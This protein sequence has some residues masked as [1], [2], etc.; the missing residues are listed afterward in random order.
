MF[1]TI[2][3][4]VYNRAKLIPVLF[5]SLQ[6][7]SCHD[8]E[9][10]V[11]DDGSKDDI[12]KVMS[13]LMN[14][15]HAF[16]IKFFSRRNGGKHRA[17]NQ[18]VKKAEGKYFFIVDSDDKLTLDAVECIK[19][20]C[21]EID[22]LP[23]SFKFAGVSGLRET[24]EGKILGESG[25]GFFKVDAS[26]LE[27]KKYRLRGDKAEIYKTEV[28]KKYPFKEIPHENFMTEE[29]VWNKIAADGYIL[30]WYMKPI[31]IGDYLAGG[32]TKSAEKRDQNNYLGLAYATSEA[33]KLKKL[34]QKMGDLHYFTKI[35]LTKD[36]SF[37]KISELVNLKPII[38]WLNFY[39]YKIL[40]NL[41][42]QIGD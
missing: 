24:P 9:W 8:F 36:Y 32:L 35:G 20:W 10:I 2:F 23:D 18:A 42:K 30:R 26:N 38:V 14:K 28:L 12:A 6:E 16:P 33:L 5:E 11:I 25:T 37:K 15:K 41:K 39:T 1:L 27:R 19:K 29:T 40:Y 3:T 17:I 22:S 7:Q 31:Y 4:P 21:A 13:Q 34:P